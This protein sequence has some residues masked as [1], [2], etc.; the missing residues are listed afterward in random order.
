MKSLFQLRKLVGRL[1]WALVTYKHYWKVRIALEYRFISS[2]KQGII[3]FGEYL[4]Q[5]LENPT[6]QL[7]PSK[8][9]VSKTYKYCC[10]SL[11]SPARFS[12]KQWEFIFILQTLFCAG[13]L[14]MGMHGLGFGC[15]REPLPGAFAK[16]GC[17]V[18]ASDLESNTAHMLGWVESMQHADSLD[19][20]YSSSHRIIPNPFSLSEFNFSQST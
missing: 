8:Q 13:K 7:C 9:I 10:D 20:L 18:T 14:Q 15:G 3:D 1:P 6:S 2:N 5:N 4:E 16:F 12:R 17:N 19:Q 11:H